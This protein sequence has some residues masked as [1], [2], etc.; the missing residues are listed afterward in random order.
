MTSLPVPVAPAEVQDNRAIGHLPQALQDALD[1]AREFA[2]ASSSDA[3]RKAYAA[4]FADFATWCSS[5]QCE[6]LPAAPP[7]VA[8]YLA[9]LVDRGL[10]PATIRRR[11]AA[12][13]SAHK[14]RGLD[15]PT[16][17]E[18]VTAVH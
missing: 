3:T 17:S 18:P 14:R 10:K 12:I 1:G 6:S 16:A 7:V 4:D 8:A 5:V 13:R 2:L 9:A 15:S 11:L